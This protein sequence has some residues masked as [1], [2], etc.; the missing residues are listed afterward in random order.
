[1]QIEKFTYRYEIQIDGKPTG[2]YFTKRKEAREFKRGLQSLYESA[3][4]EIRILRQEA[5]WG[6]STIVS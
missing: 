4:I 3:N 2:T 6:P 5:S 1:M